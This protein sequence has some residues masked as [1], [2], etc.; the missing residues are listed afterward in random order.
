MLKHEHINNSPK[1]PKDSIFQALQTQTISKHLDS[2]WLSFPEEVTQDEQR[3]LEISHLCI[4]TEQS[5]RVLVVE[6]MNVS[7][8]SEVLILLFVLTAS[9]LKASPLFVRSKLQIYLCQIANYSIEKREVRQVIHTF[10]RFINHS[11]P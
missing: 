1:M 8:L 4:R 2:L 7:A 3:R 6:R 5:Q 9:S 11:L 10:T